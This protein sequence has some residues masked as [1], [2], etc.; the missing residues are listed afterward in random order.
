MLESHI[1][2]DWPIKIATLPIRHTVQM[3]FGF[4]L[5]CADVGA[6]LSDPSQEI[7]KFPFCFLDWISNYQ[8]EKKIKNKILYF[9]KTQNIFIPV[10]KPKPTPDGNSFKIL[11]CLAAFLRG[12]YHQPDSNSK[13]KKKE[14]GNERK[15]FA[16]YRMTGSRCK[17]LKSVTAF[18]MH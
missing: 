12:H 10:T 14:K 4:P 1:S 6:Q 9:V 17:L 18:K 11:T 7:W 8:E 15:W 3:L 2:S 5:R 16:L 13:A